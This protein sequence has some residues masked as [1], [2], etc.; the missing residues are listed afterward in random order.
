MFAIIE[1]S[2]SQ[3]KVVQGDQILV[4]LRSSGEAKPGDKVTFDKVLAIGEIGGNAKIGQPYVAGATV[5]GE[6]VEPLVKGEK[7]DVWHFREKK[8]WQRKQGHRQKYT[9]VKVTAITG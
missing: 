4:D 3:R 8:A 7:I 2:G 9:M 1:D 5:Q 6:V